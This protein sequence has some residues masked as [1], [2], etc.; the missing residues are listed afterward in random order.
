M[1]KIYSYLNELNS[2]KKLDTNIVREKKW[3][4][5]DRLKRAN[6]SGILKK[7]KNFLL[8]KTLPKHSKNT[9]AKL[10]VKILKTEKVMRRLVNNG[11]R[12]Q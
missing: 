1:I 10:W 3:L 4:N 11:N 8:L 2:F 9:P 7:L 12:A 6:P 5:K